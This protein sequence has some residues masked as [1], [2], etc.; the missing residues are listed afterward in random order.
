MRKLVFTLFWLC[1]IL[2][3]CGAVR[4]WQSTLTLPTY[5]EGPPDE[6]PPFEFFKA[7]QNYPYTIRRNFTPQ[8][9]NKSWRTLEI[10][11]EYLKCI[12]IPDLGGRIY[13]CTDKIN[14]REM[15]YANTVVKKEGFAYRGAF[16]AAGVVPNFPVA[17]GWVNVSPVDFATVQNADGSASVFTGNTDLVEGMRWVVENTLRPG[18]A[19]LEQRVTLSN[20]TALRRRYLWWN[21]AGIEAATD[22]RFYYPAYLTA[23]HGLSDLDTWPVDHSGTD[24]SALANHTHGGFGRFA[25]Q[26]REPFMGVYSRQ[27]DSGTV[28]YADPN[29]V[30]GKKVWTWGAGTY[31]A[32]V[33]KNITDD[34]TIYVEMQAGLFENQETYGFMEPGQSLSFTEFWMPVRGLGGIARSS[35]DAAVFVERIGDKTQPGFKINLNVFHVISGAKVQLFAG[36]KMLLDEQA[37]LTP[38][39]TFTRTVPGGPAGA[40]FTLTLTDS[41]GKA[42][43]SHTEDQIDAA[44]PS[45]I[46]LGVQ[47]THQVPSRETRTEEQA[48]EI[49]SNEERQGDLLAAKATY[50]A[51]IR[52]AP[53]SAALNKASGRLLVT[54]LQYE[55][56]KWFLAKAAPDL[57]ARFY[58]GVA[59]AR[60]GDDAKGRIEFEAARADKGTGSAAALELAFLLTRAGNFK[61]ALTLLPGNLPTAGAGALQ[62][63]LLRHAGNSAEA[64]KRLAYWLARDPS[65]PMLQFEQV[66]QGGAGA[67]T[68]AAFWRHLSA[69]PER[70]LDIASHY[71]DA[72]LYDDAMEVLAYKYPEADPLESEPGSVLPQDHPLVSYYRGY[73]RQQSGADGRPDFALGAQQ[74][75]L[76]VFPHR[77]Q[78]FRVLEAALKAN[79][80]DAVAHFLFGSLQMSSGAPTV[81][82]NEWQQ[83]YKL[84]ARLPTLHALLG[85]MLLDVKKDPAAALKVLREGMAIDPRNAE[86]QDNVQK[87]VAV[88]VAAPKA[89]DKQT[90]KPAARL[91]PIEMADLAL[92]MIEAGRVSEAADVFTED[93]FPDAK[94]SQQVREAFIEMRVAKLFAAAKARKCD[95]ALAGIEALDDEDKAIPFTMYGF[96]AILRKAR[97]QYTLA[98]LESVCGETKMARKRWSKLAKLSAREPSLDFAYGHLAEAKLAGNNQGLEEALHQLPANGSPELAYARGLLQ[99][100]LGKQKEADASFRDAAQHAGDDILLRHL[101][102]STPYD[103]VG[104]PR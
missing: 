65:D 34:G 41:S 99:Q 71:M 15:F 58:L 67:D 104:M 69:S 90:S 102:Q 33:S 87:A 25:Y 79:P 1:W 26:S 16:W 4:V 103:S 45:S 54:L 82:L 101:A 31:G 70:V 24:V 100:A 97:L 64:A 46:K 95:V 28:H 61:G 52:M 81:A 14:R 6:N 7:S 11:N 83:A 73:C 78:S 94:Q 18:A 72:R 92:S 68:S 12:V 74:S 57:E 56:S 55:E 93:N 27:R 53:D 84:N 22:T 86:V 44:L 20:P 10:E 8:R 23:A 19:V 96:G 2:P 75:T 98:R 62:V 50:E 40:K 48:L 17:H 80:S 21:N 39:A 37:D 35:M 85:R 32:D 29:V 51:A 3:A 60:L 42:L 59:Y 76:Y 43:L 30:H 36:G 9:A 77:P 88:S 47:P 5:E 63:A 66:K 38:G 89:V 49:G 91:R 13:S